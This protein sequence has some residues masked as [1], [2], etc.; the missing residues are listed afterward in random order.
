MLNDGVTAPGQPAKSLPAGSIVFLPTSGMA[1]GWI[2]NGYTYAGGTH[3]LGIDVRVDDGSIV[4]LEAAESGDVLRERLRI[5]AGD[6]SVLALAG[7][8]I[9]PCRARPDSATPASSMTPEE[10]S[11]DEP[12]RSGR[13]GSSA[14]QEPS[15]SGKTRSS[16]AEEP[17]RSGLPVL[18]SCKEGVVFLGFGNNELLGGTVRSTF[19]LT[20]PLDRAS[21]WADDV[22]LVLHGRL[23]IPTDTGSGE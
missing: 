14:S 19:D 8:G 15:R 23:V 18:D 21:L 20:I 22:P 16:A 1:H 7:F 11:F 4:E 13:A 9:N 6:A 3:V 2:R 12:W 10:A 17:S 5:A